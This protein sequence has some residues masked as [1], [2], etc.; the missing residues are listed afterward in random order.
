MTDQIPP[1]RYTPEQAI[2]IAIA[3]TTRA[4][5]EVRALK[6]AGSPFPP[7]LPWTD[8]VHYEGSVVA[9]GGAT[10]QAT[11]DTGR[12]PPHEDWALLAAPGAAGSGFSVRGTFAADQHYAAHDVVMLAGGSFVALRDDPG[13]CP[14]DGWQLM[15][16]QGKAGPPGP[17]GERGE[18]GPQGKAGPS[19]ASLTLSEDGMLTLSL[20]DGS[21][22][23]C[24]FYPLLA[25][26]K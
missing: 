5:A 21:T 13:P 2:A 4:I 16:R 23:S 12:E 9:C 7:A 25:Q 20:S 10:W 26:L 6:V 11:R 22:L 8:R 17:R 24:D 15:S 3:L 14:G 1:P 18:A 19:A